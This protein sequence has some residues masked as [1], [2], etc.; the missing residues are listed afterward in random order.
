MGILSWFRSHRSAGI[1]DES[2]G[3]P[4]EPHSLIRLR[5]ED[6]D[7]EETEEA[8]AADVAAVE[9]DAKYFGSDSRADRDEL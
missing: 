5:Y 1:P 9:E 8:A 4:D 2:P 7:L 3:I 6:P